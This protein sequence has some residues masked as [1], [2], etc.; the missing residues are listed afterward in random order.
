[1]LQQPLVVLLQR[2]GQFF[3]GKGHIL[4]VPGLLFCLIDLQV[5][6]AEGQAQLRRHWQQHMLRH[7][8][9]DL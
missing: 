9:P 8:L 6:Q 5:Q 2:L 3:L 4:M 1:M 7:P